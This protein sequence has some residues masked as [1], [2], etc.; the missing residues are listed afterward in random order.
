LSGPHA[1]ANTLCVILARGGSKGIPNKN[2]APLLNR[3][4]IHYAITAALVS[5]SVDSLVVSSDSSEILAIAEQYDGVDTVHR[6]PELS[7][8]S[9]ASL[10]A[11]HDALVQIEESSGKHFDNILL[12][13]CVAPM[14][15]PEDID[16]VL[17]VLESTDS[18]SAVTV[19]NVGDLHPAKLKVLK[20][21]IISQ[22]LEDETQF[23]RQ[24]LPD[25]YIRNSSCYAFSRRTVLAGSLYGKST[26]GHVVPRE[27]FVNIDEP[28]DLAVAEA[29]MKWLANRST[30]P[31]VQAWVQE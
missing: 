2:I 1:Q 26:A 8:D 17:K 10:P 31:Y 9:S 15:I 25:V 27:R 4:L 6:G 24:F 3:P 23:T 18:D 13:Q 20:D 7:S 14:V 16:Q 22:Y 11:I 21:D 30:D 28:V 12:L 19:V 29:M 5:N